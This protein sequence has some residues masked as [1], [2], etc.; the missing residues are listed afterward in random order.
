[1]KI[2]L[3]I[4]FFLLTA[5]GRPPISIP[6]ADPAPA[7]PAASA[8]PAAVRPPETESGSVGTGGGAEKGIAMRACLS[9][10][11]TTILET[12]PPAMH[13][14]EPELVVLKWLANPSS[15]YIVEESTIPLDQEF[16]IIE[17]GDLLVI[18]V[19]P[20]FVCDYDLAG[21]VSITVRMLSH[22]S[23]WKALFY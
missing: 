21:R 16:E 9:N 14:H 15:R 5:C 6:K 1:M 3:L 13:K 19:P 18:V 4:C 8:S 23:K 22:S 10:M 7:T 17:Q 12:K 20:Y 11:A 2:S